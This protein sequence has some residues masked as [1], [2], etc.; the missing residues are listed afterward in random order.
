M[1]DHYRLL[2]HASTTLLLCLKIPEPAVPEWSVVSAE[3]SRVMRILE[4]FLP[5]KRPRVPLPPRRCPVWPLCGEKMAL[6][7]LLASV[8]VCWRPAPSA[9]VLNTSE[10]AMYSQRFAGFPRLWSLVYGM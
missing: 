3:N 9:S 8:H 1:E 7:H 4:F 5:H 6:H 10:R 2:I